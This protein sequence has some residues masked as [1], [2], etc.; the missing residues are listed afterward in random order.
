M[1]VEMKERVMEVP[2]VAMKERVMEVPSV[3]KFANLD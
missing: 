2:S 1:Q 3:E